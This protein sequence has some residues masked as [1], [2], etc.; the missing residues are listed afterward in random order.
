MFS[1]SMRE[2]STFIEI[3]ILLHVPLSAL[4]KSLTIAT[5]AGL[6]HSR[7]SVQLLIILVHFVAYPDPF[8]L[9]KGR[10][11]QAHILS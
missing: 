1:A 10:D 6:A 11:G 4:R 2:R 3:L 7:F 8:L 9:K 5:G